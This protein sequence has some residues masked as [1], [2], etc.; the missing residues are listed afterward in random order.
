VIPSSVSAQRIGR[1]VNPCSAQIVVPVRSRRMGEIAV[2]PL[3]VRHK[4]GNGQL[5][6]AR[7]TPLVSAELLDPPKLRSA[8]SKATARRARAMR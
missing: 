5:V 6:A 4:G 2:Q 7:S 8:A 3:H 1:E